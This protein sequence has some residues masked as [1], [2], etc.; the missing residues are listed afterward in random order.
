[1]RILSILTYY[2]PH[3]TGLTQHA[4]HVA[5]GLAARGHDVTV[6]T[7]RYETAANSQVARTAMASAGVTPGQL[8]MAAVPVDNAAYLSSFPQV[9]APA[10]ANMQ[11]A[12]AQTASTPMFRSLYQ[13]GDRPEPVSQ[14]VR[15]LWGKARPVAQGGAA[16]ADAPQGLGLF[17]DTTGI[18]SG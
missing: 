7:S 3:W 4:Q 2:A 16:K 10:A 11:V 12:S 5:E 8:R 17:S 14:T 6:L 18:F 1:M 15:D 9:R 13:T